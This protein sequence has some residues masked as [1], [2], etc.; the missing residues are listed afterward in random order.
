MSPHIR[1]STSRKTTADAATIT[2]TATS[3]PRSDW[4]TITTGPISDA[5]ASEASRAP[6]SVASRTGAGVDINRIEGC[7][8]AAPQST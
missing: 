1:A 7:S 2:D 5:P 3:P 4:T 6:V 8:A